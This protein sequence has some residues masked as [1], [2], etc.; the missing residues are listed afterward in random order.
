MVVWIRNALY[1]QTYRYVGG[2]I[3]SIS[4]LWSIIDIVQTHVRILTNL[5][6]TM[7]AIDSQPASHPSI[8]NRIAFGWVYM[9]DDMVE[10]SPRRTASSKFNAVLWELLQNAFLIEYWSTKLLYKQINLYTKK[11]NHI[12]NL[13]SI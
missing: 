11:K 7:F 10:D 12:T 4:D 5:P 13:L 8:F 1:L 3:A 2:D 9:V 6:S